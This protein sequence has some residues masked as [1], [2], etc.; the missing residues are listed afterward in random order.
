MPANVRHFITSDG[1]RIGYHVDD[2]TDPWT[3]PRVLIM[4]HSAMGHAR[5]FYA[6][7]PPLARHFRV[8]RMDLRGHGESQVPR[9]DSPLTMDR[10]VQDVVELMDH[11]GC[12]RADFVGNSAGGYLAQRLAMRDPARVTTL[13]L[14][15]STPGL[16]NSQAA[17]WL[18]RVAR[19][20]LRAFLADTITDRFS[21]QTDPGLIR[22]F[23]DEAA[24][25]DTAYI[26]RFIGLMTTLDWSDELHRIRCPTLVVMPGAETVGSVRNYEVMRERI[27]DVRVLSYEGM[28]HNICDADPARCA[29]DVLAF[30]RERG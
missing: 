1:M 26:A 25:N 15:G 28:P 18:P 20:G 9:A 4:L 3:E 6:M 29:A 10:L 27:P 19:E 30:V 14:F 11:L 5:R 17:T 7:V 2:F 24:K 23:L 22:W 12:L 16:K 21:P 13:A 8:V